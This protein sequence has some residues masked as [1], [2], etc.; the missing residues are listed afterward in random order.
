MEITFALE[1]LQLGVLISVNVIQQSVW[2]I[3]WDVRN[4]ETMKHAEIMFENA[5]TEE[6]L[7]KKIVS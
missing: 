5:K 3:S 4:M 6:I 1:P 7:K 2:F